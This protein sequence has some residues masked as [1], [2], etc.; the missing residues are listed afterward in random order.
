MTR[1][2]PPDPH[3][4]A[5]GAYAQALADQGVPRLRAAQLASRAIP[6]TTARPPTVELRYLLA[7]QPHTAS[8]AILP[9]GAHT[10]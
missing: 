10:P 1:R 5:V 3:L 2:E 4:T 8:L 6:R 9:I 7:V